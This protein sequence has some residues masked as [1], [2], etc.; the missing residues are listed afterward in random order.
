MRRLG[1]ARRRPPPQ[2]STA[3]HPLAQ[4]CPQASRPYPPT[5]GSMYNR[6]P[7][8]RLRGSAVNPW[9]KWRRGVLAMCARPP[10]A[11]C[12]RRPCAAWRLRRPCCSSRSG[13]HCSSGNCNQHQR[14]L[15]PAAT[16]T[17][18]TSSK[19][20]S[21]SHGSSG[22]DVKFIPGSMSGRLRQP[23]GM[24]D[25]GSR[26]LAIGSAVLRISRPAHCLAP[27]NRRLSP[28]QG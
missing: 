5:P 25:Q 6:S 1:L 23:R 22:R 14:Q 9:Q 18:G 13:S 11:C 17:S 21:C 2:P 10:L 16:A 3:M 27:A 28:G 8:L 7:L 19:R 20:S 26:C 15:Q 4:L 24:K 12:C